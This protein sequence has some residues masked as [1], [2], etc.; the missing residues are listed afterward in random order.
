MRLLGI[1]LLTCLIAL[2]ESGKV[3]D[4]SGRPI[5]QAHVTLQA[6][7][8]AIA[9]QAISDAT[10]SFDLGNVPRGNYLLQVSAPGFAPWTAPWSPASAA[11]DIRLSVDPLPQQTTV[12]AERGSVD[13]TD[14][15]A[16]VVSVRD[17]ELWRAKPMP[18]LGHAL[19]GSPSI[20]L[21]QT[22]TSQISPFLRGL[23][24][25]QVLNLVDGVRFNN[26][27]FRSGPNQYLAYVEQ[28]QAQ[29]IESSLGPSSAQYGSDSLGGTIQ[30]LTRDARYGSSRSAEVHG[31][32]NLFGAS[33][34]LSG[35]TDGQ[36]LVA[37]EHW[38]WLGGVSGR[39][40]NNLRA[41][42]GTDSR[43][44]L[45][46]FFGLS[47]SQIRD[48][49]GNR[50]LDTGFS[51]WGAHTKFA[52]RL[53]PTQ[54]L[55]VWYQRSDQFDT[56]NYKD[57][58]GGLGRLQSDL[59]PQSLNFA[60]LRYEKLG[61]G[62]LDSLSGTFSA[63]AQG[64]GSARQNLRTTDAVT[65][66]DS[67][68]NVFGY[69][70][71]ATTHIGS[72]QSISFGG[73]FYDERISSQRLTGG[74]IARPLYPTGSRYRTGGLFIQDRFDF[75]RLK[76]AAGGRFTRVNFQTLQDTFGTA[77]SSQS[78][79]DWTYNLSG[80]YQLTSALA[81]QALIGRGFRAPNVND[82]GAVGL[83]DLGY[84][85]PAA[86]APGA[87][88]GS[89]AAENATSLGRE[90]GGLKPEH[91][92][93]YEFGARWQSNRLYV[94][95]QLYA[96]DLY[97]PIVR[98]TLLFPAD[99]VPTSLAGLPVT[100]IA[101]TPAQLTQ[102][103]RTVATAVDPRAVKA[104]VNDGRARYY[105]AETIV[106]FTPASGWQIEGNY[107]YILGRDLNPN[108]NIRRLP[109]QQGMLS[110]RRARSRYWWQTSLLFASAQTRLS[111]GDRDDERIGASRSR[112]D[113]AAFFQGSRI[114]PYIANGVFTPTGE[115]LRQIQDRLLPGTADGTRIPLYQ[116]T[117][118]W[119][120]WN[121]QGGFPLNDW[122]SVSGGVHNVLDRNYRVHGSGVDS[123]GFNA[124]LGLRFR[125]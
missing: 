107:S 64:D 52:A 81:I 22:S 9:A 4:P 15:S 19:E 21:Q 113:I 104:F 116:E 33:A 7:S 8:G 63:N 35:G 91:L 61:I 68:V 99:R 62:F 2:A 118:G 50:Q 66:D 38:S 92:L 49:T 45:R 89:S 32:W 85:I 80:S 69:T 73:E 29:R 102:G 88:L 111:G 10:G 57:L 125:F 43:H 1:L 70:S 112:S 83:N 93:N 36:I 16:A 13:L 23:T 123:P 31:E 26:S 28:S 106:R 55:S 84:E 86:E 39:K 41:G 82:I 51:Q 87:L 59:R 76:L 17:R 100:V 18:T 46:R 108:R 44:V 30:V 103:V 95:A 25:Y 109:P 65:I 101:P 6:A 37:N 119:V 124:F 47:D 54:L 48:L 24:G 98:R 3:L 75:G 78:F 53:T 67:Q 121:V 117:A 122:M 58:W 90:V 120:T 110:L 114:A 42:G 60:Y 105:G 77:E 71:Q 94:R 40:H 56:K 96:S 97:D 20:L 14:Q 72:W 5:P 115:T 12:T 74:R 34:D 79:S 27:T 11:T